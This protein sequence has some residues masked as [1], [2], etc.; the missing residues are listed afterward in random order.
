[1][2]KRQA[3]AIGEGEITLKTAMLDNGDVELAVCD[4]GPGIPAEIQAQVFEPF[5]T[6]KPEGVGTG[7]GLYICKNIIHECGGDILLESCVDRG[8]VF[9]IQLPAS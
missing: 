3:Q 7:L 6:T 9:R 5:F 1:M 2:Y 8:T 4:D